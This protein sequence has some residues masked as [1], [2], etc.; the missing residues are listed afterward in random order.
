MASIHSEYHRFMAHLAQREVHDDVRRFAL[1]VLGHLQHLAEVGATRRGR[2]TR[3]VPLAIA[4]M[5]QTPTAY[6]GDA[7]GHDSG[8]ELGRLHQ[9]VDSFPKLGHFGTCSR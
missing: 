9:L 7:D 2:S 1:L 8:P 5:A 6:D 4:H 3:L